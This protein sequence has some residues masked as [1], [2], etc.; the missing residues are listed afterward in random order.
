MKYQPK[1]E[2]QITE[3]NLLPIGIYSF[4]VYEAADKISKAG[5]DMIELKLRLFDDEGNSRGMVTDYLLESISYK[6][7]HAAVS[8]G[9]EATYSNGELVASDFVNK[10]GEVKIR[11]QED[12]NGQFAARNVVADYVVKKDAANNDGPPLGHPANDPDVPF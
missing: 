4:E 1:S 2:K 7:R 12:K 9:L 3:E 5:N 11:I 8:C 6:L 10:T